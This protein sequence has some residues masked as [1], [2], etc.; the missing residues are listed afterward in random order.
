M[1]R[2]EKTRKRLEVDV[3]E[4][5]YHRQTL[6][7][8]WDQSRLRDARVLVVGAGAL[9]NELVKNLVLVGVGTI[10]LA[11]FDRVENSNLARCVFFR[12]GDEGRNKAEVVAERAGE[13][14]PEVQV[15][16]LVGDVRLRAGL[17]V[18]AEVDVVLGGLDNREARLFVNQACWKTSTPWIDGA[19]E[20]LMG[21]VRVFD[22]PD[23]SCYECTLSQADFEIL[24]SRRTCAL[25]SRDDM[26]AGKVPTTATTSSVV[27]GV[28][29]QEAVKLIH[30]DELGDPALAG[31]GYNFVG[32]T[33]DS[34]VVTYPRRGDCLSH[35]TY[36]L[37]DVQVVDV[38]PTFGE[39]L[40]LAQ[41]ALGDTAVLDLEHEV[42]LGA[43]CGSCGESSK[44]QQP[45]YALSAGRGICATCGNQ[46]QLHFTHSIDGTQPDLLELRPSDLGLPPA[47]I[48][49]GRAG[50]DRTYFLLTGHRKAVEIAASTAVVAAP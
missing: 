31:A 1:S 50:F 12:S 10:I 17:G 8:W 28:Q 2:D 25:L 22:P 33:H 45:I 4:G 29:V 13:L 39:L 11:D 24:A 9:G 32:L 14:N 41:Q 7:S 3:G 21:L 36:E 48:I 49:V 40:A 26:L 18:F 34:Y 23:S 6:I 37:D 16:P 35:D 42:V 46:W 30:R 15:V 47:D 19:I 20:G 5:R 27:A 43:S 38:D 44:I